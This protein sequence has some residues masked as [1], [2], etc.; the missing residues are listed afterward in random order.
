MAHMTQR[1]YAVPKN[2]DFNAIV[3]ALWA[4]G[5]ACCPLKDGTKIN[6]FTATG[7]EKMVRGLIEGSPE[8][9]DQDEE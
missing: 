4:N 5:V 3:D 7:Q 1:T 2:A 6:V 8:P 9:E